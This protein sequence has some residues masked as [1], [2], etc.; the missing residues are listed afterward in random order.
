MHSI[1]AN[2]HWGFQA[3]NDEGMSPLLLAA[4]YGHV[5]V[6]K[7]LLQVRLMMPCLCLQ[8]DLML[9]SLL[10]R[11]ALVDNASSPKPSF[12][13]LALTS[14]AVKSHRPGPTKHLPLSAR[15]HQLAVAHSTGRV[16]PPPRIDLPKDVP[17][18]PKGSTVHHVEGL[19]LPPGSFLLFVK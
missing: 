9:V 16:A 8:I 14:G 15:G 12:G 18:A 5:A 13:D 11:G 10:Q 4:S 7:E 19:V 2:I 1:P 6:V 17:F 3:Q